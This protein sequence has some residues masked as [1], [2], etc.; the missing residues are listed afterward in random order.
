M[1]KVQLGGLV[2]F[3]IETAF[4]QTIE[5]GAFQF[6][7][8]AS[9]EFGSLRYV[10]IL[11]QSKSDETYALLFLVVTVDDGKTFHVVATLSGNVKNGEP[12]GL[13]AYKDEPF[14]KTG[15]FSG[16]LTQCPDFPSPDE[17]EKVAPAKKPQDA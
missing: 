10:V 3:T 14:F 9:D 5:K 7:P 15:K 1:H 17:L 2:P 11:A 13:R 4:P 12:K 6:R 16:I 8:F